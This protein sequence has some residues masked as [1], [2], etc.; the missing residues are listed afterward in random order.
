MTWKGEC[1]IDYI[2]SFDGTR[3]SIDWKPP[4]IKRIYDREFSN[5]PGIVSHIPI[6]DKKAISILNDL[7]KDNT[8]ILPTICED[9]NF[10]LI[11]VIKVLDCIDYDKSKFKTFR[12]GKRIMKFTNYVFKKDK[13]EGVDIFKIKDEPLKRPFV[14]DRFRQRVIDNSLTGFKFELVWDSEQ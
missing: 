5:T 6:F 2:K 1:N 9:G 14:T 11:N 7:L 13:I 3:K 10:Y 4:Q 8:E 12:D